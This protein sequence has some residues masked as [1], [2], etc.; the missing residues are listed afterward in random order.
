MA[1]AMRAMQ[2]TALNGSFAGSSQNVDTSRSLRS[3]S[4]SVPNTRRPAFSL[5]ASMKG[6]HDVV[7]PASIASIVVLADAGAANALT[8]DDITGAYLKVR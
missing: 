4:K 7:A 8:G 1:Q 3:C 2:V 5:R 6:E